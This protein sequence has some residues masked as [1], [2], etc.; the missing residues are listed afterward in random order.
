M[1]KEFPQLAERIDHPGGSLSGGEQQ[2]LAI[3]RALMANPELILMDEPSEGLSPRL[4]LQV[5]EIMRR[6]RARGHAILLVEQNLELALSVADEVYVLSAGRFVFQGAPAA[7][8][9]E[10][11][12]LDQ[13]LGVSGAKMI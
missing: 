1:L 10:T 13:H 9:N 6:L 5:Q 4:V 2:M 3:G 11:Q 12:V 7:L 8:A